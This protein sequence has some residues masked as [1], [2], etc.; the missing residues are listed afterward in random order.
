MS[1]E[2]QLADLTAAV[3]ELT[4]AIKAQ[5]TAPAKE[6]AEKPEG[7]SGAS[8]K[9][10]P[11][12]APVAQPTPAADAE[13]V[14]ASPSDAPD[15]LDYETDVKPLFLKLIAAKGREAGVAFIKSFND[16]AA[17]LSDALTPD[18]YP[19]AVAKLKELL[20]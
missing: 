7:K 1:I 5:A 15:Q 12:T 4:A 16:D 20:G 11:A 13:P 2:N 18:Q 9:D 17:K 3:R 14:A 6:V 10:A 19:E 8:K